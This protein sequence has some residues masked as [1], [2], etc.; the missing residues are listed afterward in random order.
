MSKLTTK[1][2][3]A[4]PASDYAGPNRSYPVKGTGSAASDRSHAANAKA[5][6]SA[7]YNEGNMSK[8][9][10]QKINAAA[11]KVLKAKK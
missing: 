7:Q 5:R 1:Q 2:R 10:L 3:K 6:A 11:N 9:T 4:M 8:G